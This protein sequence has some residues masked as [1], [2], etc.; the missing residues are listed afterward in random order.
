MKKVTVTLPDSF[1]NSFMEFFKH[2]PE[3][4]IKDEAPEDIPDWHKKILDERL[5]EHR[6]NPNAGTNWDD[7]EKELDNT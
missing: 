5:T 1:Y 2:I 3:I 4:T 7:F 6:L